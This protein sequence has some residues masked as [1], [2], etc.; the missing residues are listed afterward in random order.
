MNKVDGELC[1]MCLKK[2]LTLMED[3]KDVPYFGKVFLFGMECSNSECLFK[4]HDLEAEKPQDP[5]K[6]TFTCENEEDLKVRVIKSSGAT[7]NIPTLRMKSEPG[8]AAEGFI[9]NIEGLLNRFEKIVEEQRDAAEDKSAKTTAKN[10][11]KKIRKIKYGE[12]PCKFIIED[13]TGNS[14]IISDKAVVEKLKKK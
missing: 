13:P 10:L 4:Q 7:L 8:P 11:L 9:T 1:P 5:I 2:T 6:V 3:K 12:I 14:M